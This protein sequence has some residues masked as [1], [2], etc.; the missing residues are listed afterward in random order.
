MT[1][2]ATLIDGVGASSLHLPSGDWACLLDFLEQRFPA[3]SRD[4][5][6][7]RLQ[8]GKVR[9]AQGVQLAVDSPYHSG[10]RIHYYREVAD[11]P[12][13]PF[14]ARILY[15]DA[16]L[17]LA[18]KPHFLPTI[19]AGRFV[20]ESLLVRLKQQ[21]GLADLVPLHRLDRETAG[22][23]LFSRNPA[24]RDA[25]SQLFVERR[26]VKTYEAI[27][28]TR[29]DIGFPLR[30]RSRLV[31]AEPFFR[32]QE[33]EGPANTDT[34]IDRI[35]ARGAFSRYELQPRTGKKH[36]LRVHMAA[37]GMPICNDRWYPQLLDQGEDDY[38]RRLQLLARS[39]AFTDPI[40]GLPRHFESQLS[41]SFSGS[42]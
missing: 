26:I 30:R 41:L 32:M 39:L 10:Q 6:R 25:Y 37:L 4:I 11:E 20:R 38:R 7:Q 1:P 8:D 14:E 27:A 2:A 21:T 34:R 23:V 40:S 24:T 29:D 31:S 16:H 17:L 5:W 3:I 19:P 36:Q 15:R 22:L 35:E 18:D 12:R 28:A 42:R 9:D 13:I 33:I